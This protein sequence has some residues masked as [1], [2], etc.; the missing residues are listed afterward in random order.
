MVIKEGLGTTSRLLSAVAGG[1][2]WGVCGAMEES[3]Q[4]AGSRRLPAFVLRWSCSRR[5]SSLHNKIP[6]LIMVNL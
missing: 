5:M 6:T 2:S 4:L 3:D 1:I